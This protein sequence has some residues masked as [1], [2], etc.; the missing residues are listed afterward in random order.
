MKGLIPKTQ[1]FLKKNA[2]SI[3]T[4]LGAGGVIGTTI[5]AIRATPKAIHLLEVMEE[6]KENELTKLEIIQIAGPAYIP[7][8]LVGT[9]TIACI[10]GANILSVRQQASLTSAYALLDNSYKEYRN[11]LIELHGKETDLEIKDEIAKDKLK[12]S[13]L[14]LT[15]QTNDL[16]LFF[17]EYSGSFF[18]RTMNEV[19]S[20]EYE[21]NRNFALRGYAEL[22]EFYKFLGLPET[23]YG[24][25]VGWS[26]GAGEE[27]Y[28]YSW[29]D[30]EHRLVVSEDGDP[31]YREFYQIAMPFGP[32]ADFMDY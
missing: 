24:M 29:V 5:L 28:G 10:F 6:K 23:E 17:D 14:E 12:R 15:D 31:D 1:M 21:F 3:L 13:N 8:I 2:S 7:T 27:F 25:S 18:E 26:M 11:K 32:T 22:N 20:A 16:R 30:F 9:S 4:W 19:L